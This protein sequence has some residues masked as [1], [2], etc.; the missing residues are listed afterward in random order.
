LELKKAEKLKKP[1]KEFRRRSRKSPDAG[2]CPWYAETVCSYGCCMTIANLQ[3][4][5][6]YFVYL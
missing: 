6:R 5:A 2:N 3:E 4:A 1:A